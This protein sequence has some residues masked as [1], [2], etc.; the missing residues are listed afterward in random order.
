MVSAKRRWRS[1]ERIALEFLE[2]LGYK[3]IETRK[4]VK[5]NGIEIGEV[6]A[7][8]VDEQGNKYAVEIKAGRIDVSGLRQAYV[9][10]EL[11]GLKP[12]VVA[13]GFADESA[14]ALAERL[15]IKVIQLSDYFLVEAEEL[16]NIVREAIGSIIVDTINLLA[17]SKPLTPEDK[18]FLEKLVSSIT[19]SDLA[20]KT[21]LTIN[22][23]AKKIKFLQNKGIIPKSAKSF[24]MIR[25]YASISLL[26]Q[27]L[28]E[29][30]EI[31]KSRVQ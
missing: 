9:N 20:S 19:I 21:N 1:S 26:K 27:K 12:L 11:L 3:V 5:V 29:L 4:K 15:G 24:N 6:D 7:I 18:E 8:V 17:L 30:F 31:M 25:Y 28:L 2:S 13:K 22:D 10:A 16:E 14:A 23:V